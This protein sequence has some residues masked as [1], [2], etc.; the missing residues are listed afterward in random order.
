M[1]KKTTKAR[2]LGRGLDALFQEQVPVVKRES[3][4]IDRQIQ[5][6]DDQNRIIYIDIND[7][8]P[9][10]NQPRKKFDEDKIEELAESIKEHG[11]IQPLIVS[12]ADN[13]Y[14][15][16][17]GERRWRASRKAGLKTVPCIVRDLTE[18]ENMLVTIIENLQREDLD[19]VEEAKGLQQMIKTYGL[20]QDQVSKSVGKSRP[21][22]T[23]SLRLLKLS[24]EIQDKISKGIISAGH[25][26]AILSLDKEDDRKKLCDMIIKSQLSVREAEH[27][28][29]L[30]NG[31]EKKPAGKTRAKKDPDIMRIENDLK[32]KLGTRVQIKK[33]GKKG[34]IE[35]SF[36]SDDDL[37]R[38]I[39]LL[40]SIS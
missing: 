31:T 16:V 11:V 15:I 19:P 39:D 2:G 6:E 23:N 3:E 8:K 26:R 13:G 40:A 10:E 34:K 32:E 24:D 21:Y 12:S 7:I 28:A 20:T 29:A 1:T 36:F 30:M 33:N 4:N 14:M 5:N 9:N 17:A 35:L 37:N 22:I 27:H 18:E 25:A 38:I